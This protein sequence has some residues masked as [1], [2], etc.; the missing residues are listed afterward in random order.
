M[1]RYSTSGTC[2]LSSSPDTRGSRDG[3]ADFT[4]QR[5]KTL[6]LVGESG[7]G[8]TVSALAVMG[9]LP[10]KVSRVTGS[11]LFEGRDLTALSP[12]SL[13]TLRGNDIA[14]IFQEP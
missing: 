1:R 4:V 13:R 6:G 14:M 2:A 7:S 10:A 5:G 12:A 3:G 8:K 11:I 9:L